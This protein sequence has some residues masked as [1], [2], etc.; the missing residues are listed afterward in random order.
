MLAVLRSS[1]NPIDY[2]DRLKTLIPSDVLNAKTWYENESSTNK[3]GSVV[4]LVA[5]VLVLVL[6]NEDDD[7]GA[8]AEPPIP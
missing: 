8:G 6:V 5:L 1:C 3:R 4:M 2:I 7:L